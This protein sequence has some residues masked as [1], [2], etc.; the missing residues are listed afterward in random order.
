MRAGLTATGK[1]ARAAVDGL[2]KAAA[3]IKKAVEAAANLLRKLTAHEPLPMGLFA[4]GERWKRLAEA[5]PAGAVTADVGG[6]VA[7]AKGPDTPTPTGPLEPGSKG[8]DA[9]IGNDPLGVGPAGGCGVCKGTAKQAGIDAHSIVQA[10]YKAVY[11]DALTEF[12]VPQKPGASRPLRVDLARWRGDGQRT[13]AIGEIKPANER[14]YT[15]GVTSIAKYLFGIGAIDPDL[16][17]VPL[18]EIAPPAFYPNVEGGPTCPTQKLFVYP[19]VGGVY[20][21][22]CIPGFQELISSGLCKCKQ[23]IPDLPPFPVTE[24]KQAD[25]KAKKKKKKKKEVPDGA[26]LPDPA[27]A[28]WI[29]GLIIALG[30]AVAAVLLWPEPIGKGVG[31]G[32]AVLSLAAILLMMRKVKSAGQATA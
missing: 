8:P 20:G 14:G 2:G 7:V 9:P 25:N 29:F 23:D 31:A 21:Y 16:K 10:A 4:W 30:I 6:A 5:V 11:P 28:K 12:P 3:Q 32:P 27:Y 24:K 22:H 26:P 15:D 17:L 19:P 1:A 18:T 13:L